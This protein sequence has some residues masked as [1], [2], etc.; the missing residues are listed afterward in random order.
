MRTIAVIHI[1]EK[2]V[3]NKLVENIKQIIKLIPE[4]NEKTNFK[5]LVNE[6]KII[7]EVA[8]TI[9]FHCKNLNFEKNRFQIPYLN[10]K[11]SK[12]DNNLGK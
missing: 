6:T 8:N 7:I 4:S 12:K 3:R 2:S 5:F 10:M 1:L 9:N 11:I